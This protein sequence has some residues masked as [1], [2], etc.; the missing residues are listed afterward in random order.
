MDP[1]T[2]FAG[3]ESEHALHHTHHRY[4]RAVEAVVLLK[5]FVHPV[6]PTLVEVQIQFLT[7][8]RRFWGTGGRRKSGDRP[9]RVKK[10]K[11]K[12]QQRTRDRN[13]KKVVGEV[14]QEY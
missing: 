9:T 1:R 13:P 12:W 3:C 4:L 7:H 11:S 2:A 6:L 10:K 14:L 8:R 5:L